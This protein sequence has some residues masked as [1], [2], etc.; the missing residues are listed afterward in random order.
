MIQSCTNRMVK[1]G[2]SGQ[3]CSNQTLVYACGSYGV[4][5]CG[6]VGCSRQVGSVI[7]KQAFR[8][9]EKCLYYSDLYSLPACSRVPVKQYNGINW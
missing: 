4:Y 5:C 9:F 7:T 8:S 2:P 3:T 6:S 1:D